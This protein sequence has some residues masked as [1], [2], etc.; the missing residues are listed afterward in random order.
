MSPKCPPGIPRVNFQE[1]LG[2]A[3]CVE[4]CSRMREKNPD[5]PDFSGISQKRAFGI[6]K[7]RFQGKM[8]FK[9][10]CWVAVGNALL[11]KEAPPA[12]LRGKCS[13]GFTALNDRALEFPT[14]LSRGS[15]GNSSGRN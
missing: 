4:L 6:P 5:V 9:L 1:F 2:L 13:G 3:F 11:K 10:I 12:V 7:S 15:P 14:V 8:E